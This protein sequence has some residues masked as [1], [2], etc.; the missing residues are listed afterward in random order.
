M[1]V[2]LR[3]DDRRVVIF[4]NFYLIERRILSFQMRLRFLPSNSKRRY[5]QNSWKKIK[6]RK[7]LRENVTVIVWFRETDDLWEHLKEGL[8]Q[9][10]NISLIKCKKEKKK[11]SNCNRSFHRASLFLCSQNYLQL[12]KLR[13]RKDMYRMIFVISWKMFKKFEV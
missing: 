2:R 3:N 13:H 9:V 1:K 8:R 4:I 10:P 6:E 11:D 7:H 12:R 5:L